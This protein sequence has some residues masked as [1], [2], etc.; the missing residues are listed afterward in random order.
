VTAVLLPL[1]ESSVVLIP[2]LSTSSGPPGQSAEAARATALVG[3]S[4]QRFSGTGLWGS[5]ASQFLAPGDDSRPPRKPGERALGL[6]ALLDLDATQAATQAPA[7]RWRSDTSRDR[8]AI[9][10]HASSSLGG[11]AGGESLLAEP[12]VEARANE[13][14]EAHNFLRWTKWLKSLWAAI[15]LPVI[16]AYCRGLGSRLSRGPTVH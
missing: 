16:W 2:T 15:I 1:M 4:F 6:N 12:H 11:D 3:V 13:G 14:V 5:N 8:D 10:D 7:K 9:A